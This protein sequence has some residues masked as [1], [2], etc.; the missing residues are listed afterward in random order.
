MFKK[1]KTALNLKITYYGISYHDVNGSPEFHVLQLKQQGDN[2]SIVTSTVFTSIE[3]TAA[4][5]PKNHQ[6]VLILNS[7]KVFTKIAT[8]S[9]KDS[10]TIINTSFPNFDFDN[11]YFEYHTVK[12]NGLVA[13]CKKNTL[14]N[15]LE[16]F[17]KLAIHFSAISLGP[18]SI[19]TV[20]PYIKEEEIFTNH[21][22]IVLTN[23]GD[24]NS[25]IAIENDMDVRYTING[26]EVSNQFLLSFSG[27]LNRILAKNSHSNFNELEYTLAQNYTHKRIFTIG[28]QYGLGFIFGILLL[29]FLFFSSYHQE[30]NII[31]SS[32]EIDNIS[33]EKIIRLSE[34]VT[35]KE[36][37]VKAILSATSSKSSFFLD[38]IGS[39]I[40]NELLLTSLT[41]NPL[42]KR[43]KSGEQIKL[44]D[45]S[46]L[47]SGT[48]NNS[49][50]FSNWITTL[51]KLPWIANVETID[52]D[53]AG[54]NSSLFK[55][56]LL[57]LNDEQ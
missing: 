54:K 5:L 29:N 27:V 56:Q 10:N 39:S 28:I 25:I 35:L 51:E 34:K 45:N 3:E 14:D 16:E 15:L 47:I 2:L 48:S 19:A 49:G 44:L 8:T 43:V 4:A 12:D 7:S 31:K 36:E 33:K 24:L 53:Y 18:I 52:Y 42:E 23:N 22:K 6:K 37:K 20:L 55:I 32:L 40:P 13:I 46:I 11:F 1:I 17:T 9:N 41:F 38:Q 26:L 50:I 30:V 57:I 21:Q